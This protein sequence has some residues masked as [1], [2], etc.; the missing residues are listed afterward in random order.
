M[1]QSVLLDAVLEYLAPRPGGVYVDGTL[2]SGGHAVALLARAGGAARLLGVDRDA[3][4]LE[5]ARVRLAPYGDR[6]CL[7]QGNFADMASLAAGQGLAAVDG[8]VLDLGVSSDQLAAAERGF[9][10]QTDGPLDMRMDARQPLTAADL[11]RTLTEA[12]LA[13]VLWTLGEE[14]QSRRIARAVVRARA[15]APIVTTGA[16]AALV[17]AALGGRREKRH[18][19]TRTFQAL[20][21][22]VNEEL[23]SLERGLAA[24]L[25]L[26]REGGRLAV[27]TFHSLEDRI[28]KQCLRLHAGRWVALPAGG[29]VWE[30]AEP[31]VRLLTRKPVLPSPEEVAQ[32][33]RARSAKLRAAV[34]AE[35]GAR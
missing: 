35:T 7:V 34:R 15:Q 14:P 9:S 31:A 30:G 11:V 26:L 3:A 27:I 16:L 28:V 6:C 17:S 29:E 23:E 19:A 21:L 2:G 4:A 8:I 25:G 24:A 13:D 32:N 5:R 20:R 1:H 10:F 12:D 33:P 22:A 18:P